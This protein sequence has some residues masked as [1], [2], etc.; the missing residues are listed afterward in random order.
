MIRD[1]K[2]A[3][4][5]RPSGR[6]GRQRAGGRTHPRAERD[7]KLQQREWV[8]LCLD[9]DPF[10]NG[11]PE[12]G[13]ATVE[14]LPRRRF[15]E[16]LDFQPRKASVIEEVLLSRPRRT[17]QADLA[18]L[19]APRDEA[20]HTRARSVQPGKVVNDDEQGSIGGCLTKQ[21]EC[22]V[23]HHEPA[24]GRALAESQRDVEGVPVDH[25]E[26]GQL[27]QEW[28]QDLVQ[29]REA[30]PGFELDAGRMEDPSAGG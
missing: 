28:Q 30:H 23:R 1:P 4:S 20:Q 27:C 12:V 13:K 16:P 14:Q 7:R 9:Q 19:E 17:Q 18:A 22:R 2:T 26:L 8:P 29:T 15:I 6:V 3:W 24:R 11:W 21:H 5:R 10:A 25:R